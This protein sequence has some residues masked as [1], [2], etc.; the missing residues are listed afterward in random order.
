MHRRP[1]RNRADPRVHPAAAGRGQRGLGRLCT[2]AGRS[3]ARAPNAGELERNGYSR[4][5][6]AYLADTAPG[7]AAGLRLAASLGELPAALDERLRPGGRCGNTYFGLVGRTLRPLGRWPAPTT[8]A[9]PSSSRRIPG[10]RWC[11][12]GSPASRARFRCSEPWPS[13]IR[14]RTPRARA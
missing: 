3:E 9:W 8:S 7:G 4:S 6:D 1:H 14:Y 12:P 10:T 2:R 13:R 11:W 5:A